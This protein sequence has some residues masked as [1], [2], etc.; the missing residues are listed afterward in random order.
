[1][2]FEV[3]IGD[4]TCST[5]DTH[6]NELDQRTNTLFESLRKLNG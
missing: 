2:T 3:C 4:F 1:M 6:D 5:T